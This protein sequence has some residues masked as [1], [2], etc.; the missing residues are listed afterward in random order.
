MVR[1]CQVVKSHLGVAARR[2]ATFSVTELAGE[3]RRKNRLRPTCASWGLLDPDYQFLHAL[4]YH[5]TLA[6]TIIVDD[7]DVAVQF[8]LHSPSRLTIPGEG[9]TL[10]IGILTATRIEVYCTLVERPAKP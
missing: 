1:Q 4:R 6:T 3:A 5:G 2:A 9:S 10:A 7:N 8:F